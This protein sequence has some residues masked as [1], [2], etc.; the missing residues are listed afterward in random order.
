M[1]TDKLL[2]LLLILGVYVSVLFTLKNY[3]V[4]HGVFVTEGFKSYSADFSADLIDGGVGKCRCKNSNLGDV[5]LYTD[6]DAC[7][8]NVYSNPPDRDRPELMPGEL[9][10]IYRNRHPY[11]DL[12]CHLR[13]EYDA[14]VDITQPYKPESEDSQPMKYQTYKKKAYV[15]CTSTLNYEDSFEEQYKRSTTSMTKQLQDKP[16]LYTNFEDDKY[17]EDWAKHE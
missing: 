4:S 8:C 7:V 9:G 11:Y 6:A 1:K 2:L 12:N 10:Q 13:H 3:F 16:Y 5:A 17:F 15:P 14:H